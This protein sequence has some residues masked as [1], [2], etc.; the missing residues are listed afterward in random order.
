MNAFEFLKL[1]IDVCVNYSFITSVEILLLDE[2]ILKVR[3]IVNEN[4]FVNV[5]YNAST[6]KYSYA[7]I[8]DGKRIFGYD[9]LKGWHK[10]P[11]ED[12]NNHLKCDEPT[13]EDIFKEVEKIFKGM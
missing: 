11:F 8:K 3:A 1:V 5:F 13:L 9:N 10:H 4:I 7:L 6:R 2:P 12:P